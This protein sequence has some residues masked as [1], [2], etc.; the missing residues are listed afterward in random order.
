MKETVRKT[1]RLARSFVSFQGVLETAKE[2]ELPLVIDAVST[3][4]LF[5]AIKIA[6]NFI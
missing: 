6:L 4:D 1:I 5:G 2:Q 3:V